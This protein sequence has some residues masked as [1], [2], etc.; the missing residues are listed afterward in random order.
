M[1]FFNAFSAPSPTL[2][3]LSALEVQG[4]TLALVLASFFYTHNAPSSNHD[5]A[6]AVRSVQIG[7][8]LEEVEC[9][10]QFY[11]LGWLRH[12]SKACAHTNENVNTA[13]FNYWSKAT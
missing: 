10:P 6:A 11:G 13:L 9:H 3:K 12:G 1:L 7:I 4:T 8:Q 2:T 5:F